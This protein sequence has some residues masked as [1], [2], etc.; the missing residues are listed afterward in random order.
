MSTTKIV[1]VCLFLLM[2]IFFIGLSLNL[3]EKPNHG[4]SGESK[5]QQRE[6]ASDYK[7]TAGLALLTDY[8]RRLPLLLNLKTL[9]SIVR[10]QK[11]DFT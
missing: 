10:T 5:A 4:V 11:Q 6:V 1:I 7:K 3:I 9:T 8:W 2:A